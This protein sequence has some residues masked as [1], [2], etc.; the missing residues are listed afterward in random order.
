MSAVLV[1]YY[2]SE[3][4][5]NAG[6]TVE[7]R[8]SGPEFGA[9]LVSYF[10]KFFIFQWC[11]KEGALLNQTKWGSDWMKMPPVFVYPVVQI[12]CCA[13]HE[14][15][16]PHN[17]VKFIISTDWSSGRRLYWMQSKKLCCDIRRLGVP[18]LEDLQTE[19]SIWRYTMCY[20]VHSFLCSF[21]SYCSFSEN[22]KEL[23]FI[24]LNWLGVD[25]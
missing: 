11:Y 18:S 4:V 25:W 20:P 15:N 10:I 8:I 14:N 23:T 3:I 22:P 19:M 16:K 13:G 6:I 5:P 7:P 21:L 24:G 17:S 1:H 9:S 2:S 12:Q